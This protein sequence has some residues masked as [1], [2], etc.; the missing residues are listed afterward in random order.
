MTRTEAVEVGLRNRLQELISRNKAITRDLRTGHDDD[1]SEQATERENDAVL[2]RLDEAT[3]AEVTG[4][5]RALDRIAQGRYG[6]CDVCQRPI[7]AE[8]LRAL[9]MTTVCVACSA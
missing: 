7:G 1:S 5:R 9:P 4:I 2:E 3:R 6:V 8:R